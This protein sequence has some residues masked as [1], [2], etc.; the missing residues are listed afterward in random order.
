MKSRRTFLKSLSIPLASTSL[1]TLPPIV[2]AMSEPPKKSLKKFVPSKRNKILKPSALEPGKTLGMVFPAGWTKMEDVE[3]GKLFLE[4][5][6]YKVIIGDNAGKSHGYL[7]ATDEERAREFMSFVERK[8][9]DGIIC[10]RGGYGIM[11]MLPYLNFQSI[12][13][14]CKMIC[15][16]SDITALINSIYLY[17]GITCFHG[18][19]SLAAWDEF[20][21][22]NFLKIADKKTITDNGLPTFADHPGGITTISSG[23]SKGTLLGG[24]LTL[25][26]NT[27]GTPFEINTTG[28]ILFFEDVTEEPY[29]IDRMLTQ[30]L[31][32]G[33]L[34]QCAG[35][36]I[37]QFTRC[38]ASDPEHSFKIADL[39]QERLGNLPNPIVSGLQFGHVS[40]KIT[41][42]IGVKV[43]LDADAGTLSLLEHA[44]RIE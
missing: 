7:S 40:S 8:D 9:I 33:K 36:A 24:N 10:A 42:P 35:I 11:R 17:S 30:L 5:L 1:F 3:K 6:G 12:R 15:G 34:Q 25:L 21:T 27:M 13:K 2:R 41:F 31:L 39:L 19:G 4:S 16:Y 26:A 22:T 32:A 38:E 44:V 29:R 14:N 18:P 20:T 23:K 28:S 43:E 37:G